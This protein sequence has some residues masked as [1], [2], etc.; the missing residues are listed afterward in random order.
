MLSF[1]NIHQF[2][3][4]FVAI[5]FD[6]VLYHYS[7]Y[8][9]SI[10]L[11]VLLWSDLQMSWALQGTSIVKSEKNEQI[12]NPLVLPEPRAGGGTVSQAALGPGCPDTASGRPLHLTG[13]DSQVAGQWQPRRRLPRPASAGQGPGPGPCQGRHYAMSC[14]WQWS[15]RFQVNPEC[16]PKQNVKWNGLFRNILFPQRL[17]LF[18]NKRRISPRPPSLFPHMMF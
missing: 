1:V 10:F 18:P 6:I 12:M 4:M 15:T 13:S 8:Y 14:H 5:F 9:C 3:N 2:R 16:Q 11:L 7:C 17:S